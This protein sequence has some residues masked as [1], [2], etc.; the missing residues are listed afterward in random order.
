MA[1][2]IEH[3]RGKGFDANPE[4]R[5][6]TGKPKGTKNRSTI[7]KEALAMAFA[8]PEKDFKKLKAK[9]PEIDQSMTVAEIMTITQTAKAIDKAD[10]AAYKAVM[11]YAPEQL[12]DE[13]E[14]DKAAKYFK[15]RDGIIDKHYR[16]LEEGHDW[17]IEE[18]GSRSGKTYNALKWCVAQTLKGR[19]DLNLIAPSY[20]MLSNGMFLD[21]KAI[22]EEMELDV[23]VPKQTTR[24]EMPNGSQWVF[25]VVTDENE[26]KRNRGN[27]IV[28][29]ADGIPKE[30]GMLLGRAKGRKIVLFNPV[31][32]FW[33]HDNITDDESNL[34]RTTWKDNK[35]I[36]PAQLKW[37]EDLKKR[38]EFAEEGSPERYAYEVYYLGNYSLLS[39]KA[40]E[41]SDFDIVDEVPEKFDYMMSY[42]DPSLGTGNDFFAGLLFGIRKSQVW[43]VD[44]IF[45]QFT[46]ADGYIE[47]LKKWDE[48]YNHMIDHYA[49]SNGVSGVV[50]G[51]VDVKYDGVLSP[52]NNTSKKEADI[53]VYASTAK[54]FK[55]LRS[56]KMIDFLNQCA[57]F[58]NAQHDDAPDCLGRGAKLLI[59]YF[60]I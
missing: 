40:Y 13:E 17:S 51:A 59:K 42:S 49:E 10:T 25:E 32:R 31:K 14:A 37:L 6:K 54:K 55:F 44:C 43:V 19:F 5:C 48:Q 11:D 53:I 38:G 56:Q 26:A 33:A 41:L 28:D 1:G 57:E 29:E 50:T 18:G 7:I 52:V 3:I 2:E 27:V 12:G 35:F 58:P 15:I 21:V 22:I 34:L 46:K 9:Y 23:K 20:K 16:F 47:Q 39:G 24:I 4:N 60:D 30:V 36:A 45:S 8:I